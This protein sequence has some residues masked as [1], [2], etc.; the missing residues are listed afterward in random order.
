MSMPP[1]M[2][3]GLRRRRTVIEYQ[4]VHKSFDVPVLEGVD[5]TVATGETFGIIGPSG[6]GKSVLLKTTVGLITPDRGDVA[7]TASRSSGRR[8][9]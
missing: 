5:F 3:R 1:A 6:C 4:D 7:L 8:S 2:A 9:R